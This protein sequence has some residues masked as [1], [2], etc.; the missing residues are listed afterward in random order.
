[1]EIKLDYRKY[2]KKNPGVIL[3]KMPREMLTDR[4]Y[5]ITYLRDRG[6]TYQ[7][8]ADVYGFTRQYI[9]IIMN[10]IVVRYMEWRDMEVPEVAK[11]R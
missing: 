6:L 2:L 9:E 11:G 8:I 7:E 1:M 10:R 3:E 5:R 4:E